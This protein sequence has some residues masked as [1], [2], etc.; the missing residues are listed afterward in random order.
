MNVVRVYD[1][2]DNS[3][4]ES[5][6]PALFILYLMLISC[7]PISDNTWENIVYWANLCDE[8]IING[9]NPN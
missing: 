4:K 1:P 6:N 8:E 7:E 5:N 2:R 3:W 9:Y